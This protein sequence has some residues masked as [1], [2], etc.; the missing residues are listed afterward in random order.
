[1]P[2]RLTCIS[3][4]AIAAASPAFAQ[5]T[6]ADLWAEWQETS[7]AMGQSMTADVT[8]T[9]DGLVLENFVTFS[10]Q[11]GTTTTGRLERV[12]MTEGADGTVSID[13]SDPYVLT[14]TFP[15]DEDGPIITLEIVLNHENLDISVAGAAGARNY[16]YT[17]DAVTISEGN[18]TNDR[19]EPVPDI[20]MEIVA[21]DLATTY[22]MAGT[23]AD[24]QRFDSVGTVGSVAGRF[25]VRPPEAE[26]GHVKLSFALGE[27]ASEATG[28]MVALATL[29]QTTQGLPPGFDIAGSTTYAWSRLE[30]AF[31]SPSDTF[32][33]FYSNEG[34]SFGI[35]LSADALSYDISAQA[36]ET[37]VSGS[38]I[39]VPVQVTAASGALSLQIPLSAQPE[40]SSAA[41]RLAY[42]DL[43]VSDG[44]WSMIDPSGQV[45]RNPATL[46]LDATAQVQIL[47]DLMDPETMEM[48]EPPGELRALT[49]SELEIS[50]GD[51]SLTG[52]ADMTFAPGQMPPQP[53]GRA[54]LSLV[55][56]NALLEQLQAAGVIGMEQAAMAR[57]VAGMF[58]RPGAMPDTLETALE[59][60]ADGTVTANGMP[61]Q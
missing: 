52:T 23:I 26:E 51:T 18:I 4:L 25:D 30:M 12:T 59:F 14:L 53:V 8:Q 55:G 15:E 35:G 50:F 42:R 39:P 28:T 6:A 7:T 22:N 21:R 44:L 49:V 45:P 19:G 57:G 47:R 60:G 3:I 40:P 37:R 16:S 32:D 24:G 41:V 27:I 38:E 61:L 36:M 9:G 31:D 5:V 11:E 54:D 33:A 13:L 34:G 46:I 56:G 48:S 20:D 10:E 2:R 43:A 29:Q 1:M 58:T 17:A